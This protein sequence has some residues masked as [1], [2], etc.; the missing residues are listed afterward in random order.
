M[1]AMPCD[2]SVCSST[3]SSLA[4]R[5]KLGQPEP[6]SNLSSL[7]N[8]GCPQAAQ[9]YSPSALF[10]SYLPVNA[11]SVPCS[12]RMRYCS[13]VSLARHSASVRCI[14][15]GMGVSFDGDMGLRPHLAKGLGTSSHGRP[16][17]PL[18]VESG[19]WLWQPLIS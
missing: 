16:E 2:R 6:L 3:A 9:A 15:S 5:T 12:R 13:G 1:R 8:S 7:S 14:F 19:R 11:R 10:F 17:G 18:R 4:G